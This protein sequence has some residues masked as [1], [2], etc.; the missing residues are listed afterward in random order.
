VFHDTRVGAL[1]VRARFRAVEELVLAVGGRF[2]AV[3]RVRSP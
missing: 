3:E 2:A 1:A